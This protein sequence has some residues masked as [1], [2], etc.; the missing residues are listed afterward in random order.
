MEEKW[1]ASSKT[2]FGK[3]KV[4]AGD[5]YE[6]RIALPKQGSFKPVA[7]T[8]GDDDMKITEVSSD[9]IRVSI[10]PDKNETVSW[11]VKFSG[12]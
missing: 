8:L 5:L 2:L 1:D 12:L 3:S 4:V 9:G 11:S 7:A 6:L 10:V